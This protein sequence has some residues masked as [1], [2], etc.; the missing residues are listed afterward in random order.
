MKGFKLVIVR[1]KEYD[2]ILD[3]DVEQMT[4]KAKKLKSNKSLLFLNQSLELVGLKASEK[5]IFR[6][7]FEDKDIYSVRE[8]RAK[9]YVI[10]DKKPRTIEIK[11]D[12][13]SPG[14]AS[15]IALQLETPIAPEPQAPDAPEP[16][17]P[18]APESEVSIIDLDASEPVAIDIETLAKPREHPFRPRTHRKYFMTEAEMRA[19]IQRIDDAVARGDSDDGGE[20]L[21]HPDVISL[22]KPPPEGEPFDLSS[23]SIAEAEVIPDSVE[24]LP[25]EILDHSQQDD[26]FERDLQDVFDGN[27]SV[28]G[29]MGL[30]N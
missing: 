16:Q 30:A 15:P 14:P 21:F 17:A 26:D 28:L 20:P 24:D 12:P 18:I 3:F 1:S 23:A 25:G 27:E 11:S 13:I 2:F 22:G 5:S 10:L 19:H 6:N 4:I 8:K 29:A 9:I 7:I